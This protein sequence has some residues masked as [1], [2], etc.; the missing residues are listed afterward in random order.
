M[1]NEMPLIAS[2]YFSRNVLYTALHV[3]ELQLFNHPNT[4]EIPTM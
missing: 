1:R 4:P 2:Q 3:I